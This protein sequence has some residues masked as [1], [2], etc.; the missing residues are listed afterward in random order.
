MLAQ[1]F[2]LLRSSIVDGYK[3]MNIVMITTRNKD[4]WEYSLSLKKFMDGFGLTMNDMYFLDGKSKVDL[5]MELEIDIHID[6]DPDEIAFINKKF[7][8]KGWLINYTGRYKNR[9]GNIIS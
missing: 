8:G 3:F 5:I 2:A 4:E 7:P 9:N 1:V 6:A